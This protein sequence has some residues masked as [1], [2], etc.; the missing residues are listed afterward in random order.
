ML[1]I[2]VLLIDD[3]EEF[4]SAL[5]ERLSLRG[6]R[7]STC[8]RGEEGLKMIE[9][10]PPQVVILDMNMP[11][12]SGMDVL[13]RI[14]TDHP[15]IRVIL[16]TGQSPR[17]VEKAASGAGACDYLTKPVNIG[18]LIVKIRSAVGL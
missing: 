2:R 17:E 10:D 7:T 13:A 15:E 1:E 6:M 18:E 16:L 5:A 4:A 12:L 14:R 3:E 8:N 9:T 11:G